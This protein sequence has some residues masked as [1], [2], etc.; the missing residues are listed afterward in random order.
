MTTGRRLLLWFLLALYPRWFKD[1]R[2]ADLRKTYEAF[3]SEP[4]KGPGLRTTTWLLQDALVT[5]YRIRLDGPVHGSG[6]NN[7]QRERGDG[8]L[9]VIITGMSR[10]VRSLARSPGFTVV[11]VLTMGLGIG[12]NTAIF[13]VIRG[14]LWT[15]MPYEDP[16][17]LVQLNNR[18]LPEGSLGWISEAEL[19]EYSRGQNVFESLAPLTPTNANLTGLVTPLRLEGLRV[20]PGYFETLGVSPEQGRTFRPE[21][22]TPGGAEV[23]IISHGL[24]NTAFGGDP[25]TLGTTIELDG[26]Q[27]TVIG[28]MGSDV[29]PLSAYIFTG[30]RE[31]F[32]IP[33][34]IDPSTFDSRTV[35]RHN[36]LVIGRLAPG[37]EPREA[38]KALRLSVARLRERYP[39]I[40]NEGFRDVAVTSLR[41]AATERASATL[42]LLGIAVILVLVVSCVNVAN[43]LLARA[44]ARAPEMAVR[45][46]FGAE[47]RHLL[48]LGLSESIAVGLVGGALGIALAFGGRGAL[49]ALIPSAVPIPDG[50]ELGVPVIGFTLALSLLAGTFAGVLPAVR[51][52]RRGLFEVIRTSPT[53]G[54]LPASGALLRK[55]LVV[56]QVAAAVILVA[57]ASLLVRSLTALRAV[58]PGFD[59][60]GVQLIEVSATRAGYPDSGAVR[61]LYAR[62]QEELE[63]VNGIESVSASWQTPQQTGMSDWPVM[64]ERVSE[65]EWYSADPNF[66]SPG[67]FDTYGIQ[68][69]EGR[70]FDLIDAEREIGAVI[71]NE[72]AA[73]RLWGEEPVVGKR[74]N[75]DFQEPVWREVIGVVEDVRGRGLQEEPRAQTYMTF[76]EGPFS[77]NPSLTLSVRGRLDGEAL[78]REVRR[79]LRG[80]DPAIPAGRPWALESQ[81]A[82]TTERE[83]LLSTLLTLFAS[84]ALALGA[85]GVY[86]IIAFSVRQ[87]TREIGLRIAVGDLPGMVLGRVVRQ[88][89]VLGS[90][91]TLV[92]L[93]GAI[94][95]GRLLDG[96]LFGIS[97]FDPVTLVAVVVLV[98]LVAFGASWLPAR[99][100]ASV[101][102]LTALR[103]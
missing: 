40:S 27:R 22:G 42:A 66:V 75:L 101:D 37:V 23:V 78:V 86:G 71:L 85:I 74:V 93:V 14:V 70:P 24:W 98:L 36:L 48:W 65:S 83:T 88:G 10:T 4:G 69:I 46:S 97:A 33:V 16:G 99:H 45:A 84:V 11:A 82:R 76:G 67:Y 77:A 87:R 89:M 21:E 62:I 56:G 1:D 18:Y 63:E 57:S 30:R 6:E 2:Q 41:K 55:A 50:L 102:P 32:W 9:D 53:H 60:T 26:Q 8:L 44:D 59:S 5:A 54:S 3:L 96:F 43:L 80:I 73:R 103:D 13:S 12:T 94:S 91:G 39:G 34:R 17:E 49:I 29:R 81:V 28:I 25:E 95:V 35:E 72:T 68:I 51:M 100:A 38:E 15:P 7:A 61:S 31:E 92:G 58:D 52:S 47:R 79:T 20:G 90:V 64:P 19:T